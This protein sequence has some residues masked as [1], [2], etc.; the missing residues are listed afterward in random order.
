MKKIYILTAVLALLALSL[1][2]QDL[3]VDQNG[4]VVQP[5]AKTEKVKAPNRATNSV[6]VGDQSTNS[7]YLPVY[8]WWY[9]GYEQNQMIYTATQLGIPTGSKIKSITFYPYNGLQLNGGTIKFSI[10][11]TTA[12]SFSSAAAISAS[13]LT[14][15]ATI[16]PSTN[17]SLTEWT[18]TFTTDFIYN[19]GNLLVQTDTE[20][21]SDNRSYFYG[22]QQQDYVGYYAYGYSNPPGNSGRSQILPKATFTYEETGPTIEA[23]PETLTINDN[24]NTFEVQGSNL[25][26]DN[27]G[28]TVPQGSEFSTT[29]SDQNWGFVNNN[30]SVSGTVT[31]TYNGR[32]LSATETVTVANNLTSATVAV[33]YVP[34]LYIYFDNGV[35][36]WNFSANPAVAMTNQGNGN[37][38]ATLNNIPANSHILFGRA[39][40]L[41]YY[42]E[43]DDNR[44]F[45]GASTTGGDWAYGDNIS[46]YLDTDPR[47][48]SPVKYHPIYFQEG[49]TYTITINAND[50]TFTIHKL[51]LAPPENVEATPDSEHQ[52][53]TVTWEAPNPSNL[54]TGI[55]QYTE[56]F[57]NTTNF[58]PFTAGGITATTNTGAFGDSGWTLYDATNGCRVYGSTQLNYDNE[59]APHAWFVFKPSG[60]TPDTNYPNATAHGTH[61]GDQYLESIC[62]L[63]SST[64]AGKSD[65]WLISPELSGNSQTISFYVCEMVTTYGDETYEILVSTTDNNPS[66]FSQL[67]G[68]YSVSSTSWAQQSVQLPAGTKYF[69]IRHTSNNVFALL[70]DDVTYEGAAPVQISPVSYNVYL[71]GELVGNVPATDAL[72]YDFSE[73]A[74]GDHTV[75]ISAVYPGGVESEKV[76]DTFNIMER[77]ATPTIN[78]VANADGSKTIS[79]TGDGEVHLY[80]DGQEVTSPYT[81]QPGL[82]DYSVTVTATAQEQGKLISETAEQIVTVAEAGRT[83][84][85]VITVVEHGGYVEITA[86][87]DGTVTLTVDGQTVE[88]EGSA[89]I[90]IVKASEVQNVTATAT[91]QAEG[92]AGS[93]EATQ[94]VTV[95]ALAGDPTGAQTG[96]LRLHMVIVDQMKEEIPD[97]NSHPDKYGYVLRYEPNGAEGA[98]VKES[99]TVYVNIQ[100]AD[101]EVLGAYTLTEVDNDKNIG[102]SHDQGIKMDVITADVEYDLS[103]TNDMLY[104]YLLQGEKGDVPGV[105]ENVLTELQKTQNFTYVEMEESNPNKGKEYPNGEH[106]FFT[107]YNAETG[108]VNADALET[109]VYG[110]ENSFMSYAPSVSTWGIQRRYFEDD[111]LNNT[112]G[113]PLWKT[114][115]GKVTMDDSELK[116]EK[117]GNAWNSVNW[118]TDAGPAS[119]FIL[120]GFKATG[121]LPHTDIATVEYEPYMFRIFVESPSGKLRPYKTVAD[122]NGNGEHL[123][124]AD[125]ITEADMY[126]PKC[127]WNGYI[128]YGE[129]E[130]G[131]PVIIGTDADNGVTVTE[132]KDLND[133][134]Q[135]AYTYTKN[136]VDR[137]GG[138]SNQGVGNNE[139]NQDSNN[140]MFGALDAILPASGK[141]ST[142]D[143]K[144]FVRFYYAVKGEI[145]DHTVG[146][147][148][149]G[150][151]SGNGAESSGSAAGSATSVYEIAY[152]G[153]IVSQ[154]FYNVQGMVSEKPFEGINIVVTRYSNGA[155]TTT[156]VRY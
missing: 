100:K 94:D 20:N 25:G 110:D 93:H 116:A 111:G 96:L 84:T 62:P 127:V 29:T 31:V 155:T 90:T 141:I 22:T 7:Q 120:D 143:L 124:A 69:A 117:Q 79:V 71:D 119:L 115:A 125:E 45:I 81:L 140:A 70:L 40:G 134:T 80:V 97:D 153:E 67:G 32:A 129:D 128:Q 101:C 74:T 68:T 98:G 118:T 91:A 19:G 78:V 132:G 28:V 16:T 55:G 34:D 77:T 26:T 106:H 56:T 142:D 104:A 92:L 63:T 51:V 9:D 36:P 47:D 112:Y 147:R 89:S 14:Q 146:T 130:Y 57:E 126:G 103:A 24:G 5:K 123:E 6:T 42:W 8:G 52:T 59:Q 150:S 33:T 148:A 136:K 64:A 156:K 149:E 87:G 39:S 138:S 83:P 65:H 10:G 27:V 107:A 21:G 131:K 86:I 114:A 144:V 95:P 12:S 121:L 53:A 44:L 18:I 137:P 122:A 88:G 50:Y 108:V 37:Y 30:G 66:S 35:S 43:G 113:A 49:G 2:A 151:R 133:E 85:P 3:K 82:D 73:L 1:N 54:P 99:G 13:D 11:T 139:W 23:S 17:S 75:E 72:T 38:T 102:R 46:G 76:A 61:S 109:G 48:D 41:T 60:A 154:T 135:T 152:H 15:V 4:N 105:G 145:A 58:P